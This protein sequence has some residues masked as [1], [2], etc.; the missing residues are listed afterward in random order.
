MAIVPVLARSKRSG[1]SIETYA[2]MDP[3][4]SVSFC[5]DELRKKLGLGGRKARITL[6]TMGTSHTLDTRIVTGIELSNLEA[7]HTLELPNVYSKGSMPVSHVHIPRKKDIEEWPHMERVQLPDIDAE[8]GL[9]IGNDVAEA[10]TPLEIVTGPP[11]SPYASRTALGWIPWNVVRKGNGNEYKTDS[12]PSNRAEVTAI[13]ELE[14]I[15]KLNHAV[16][17]AMQI[18]FPENGKNE[19]L[20]MS[21]DDRTFLKLSN[22]NMKFKDGKFE[23]PL[24]FRNRNH[25]MP[26]NY[27][28]A[29]KRLSSLRTKMQRNADFMKDYTTFMENM[30]EKGYAEKVKGDKPD[31]NNSRIWY[32]PH[33]GV[34]HPQ[35]ANKF[36]VVFDCAA[37]FQG[38][39]L[40]DMLLQGPDLTNSLIGVLVRFRQHEI[41]LM[42]DIE[43]MFLHVKVP[44]ADRDALIFLWWEHGNLTHQ[45]TVYRM[46]SH[47]FGA[48][49]SPASANLAL[50]KTAENNQHKYSK[51]VTHTIHNNF[52]VDDCLVSVESEEEGVNLAK[53]LQELC[54]DGGF[55]LIKWISNNRSVLESIPLDERAPA[56]KELDL[57]QDVLPNE[58]ALGVYWSA[59]TDKF[60]FNIKTMTK[61]NT[62]RGLLSIISSV[63]DPLGLAAPFIL[64]AKFILQELCRKGA[65]WDDKI[66]GTDLVRWKQW[67]EELPRLEEWSMPRCYTPKSFGKLVSCQL[68]PVRMA[69]VW[70]HT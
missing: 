5:T 69:M 46:T 33:H 15:K 39:S 59:E 31:E 24:P 45:P 37:K 7:T 64:P 30:I 55:R 18:D 22:D 57:N 67:L 12:Y 13:E 40:N 47:L 2:F 32:I 8:I 25:L 62:R 58:R 27:S 26:N 48:T 36:R 49:S 56:F 65:G 28:L 61:P 21:Q 29:V 52:Y 20:E 14:E 10:Y 54:A 17:K 11:G 19:K 70:W 23:I 68:T 42:S 3:G 4:S 34:Y 1:L 50:K 53:G 9:L 16:T 66:E 44:E 43:G 38:I 63:F 41:A 60:G 6:D 35:K 51:K